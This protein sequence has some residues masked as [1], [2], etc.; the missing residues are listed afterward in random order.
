[1]KSE[2]VVQILKTAHLL[3]MNTI[4]EHCA[5]FMMCSCKPETCLQ[6]I[7][8]ANIY[9]LEDVAE[10]VQHVLEYNFAAV[11]KT[12]DFL[13]VSKDTLCKFLGNDEITEQEIDI[14]EACL[15]WIEHY[16]E[17][18]VEF[19][20]E[21]FSNIRLA[22]IK[23]PDL[24][25]RVLRCKF[26]N[27]NEGCTKLV[28]DAVQ[29]HS[30]VYSQPLCDGKI[31]QKRGMSC[32]LMI[33][34]EL[35]QKKEKITIMRH[36]GDA[37]VKEL[38]MIFKNWSRRTVICGGFLFMFGVDWKSNS[39][40]LVRV[41]LMTKEVLNL[42]PLPQKAT[43]GVAMSV[44]DNYIICAGGHFEHKQD[45]CRLGDF[46][47][48]VWMYNIAQNRWESNGKL[49]T[50]TAFSVSHRIATSG[51]LWI[52]GGFHS[53]TSATTTQF[54]FT[55][56]V[57]EYE[58]S[59]KIWLPKP[60][61][62]HARSTTHQ[63]CEIENELLMVV[64]GVEVDDLDNYC[65]AFTFESRQWTYIRFPSDEDY[66]FSTKRMATPFPEFSPPFLPSALFHQP[67]SSGSD[68][69]YMSLILGDEWFSYQ[70]DSK[71][72]TQASARSQ[73]LW[74]VFTID[75]LGMIICR[76]AEFIGPVK[77]QLK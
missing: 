11:S 13:D 50:P 8:L 34:Q 57:Y 4:V 7:R 77:L 48:R 5:D 30:N 53:Q 54:D 46:T 28:D 27:Q 49:P 70:S 14:F 62:L 35:P 67:G 60:N 2:N 23:M 19:F 9:H 75:R 24:V 16:E 40:C 61:M 69:S 42:C 20:A 37:T 56:N 21:I 33:Y 44:L 76:G 29:Y 72:W 64:G 41:D 26:V 63:V 17:E 12:A 59:G 15:R 58:P 68:V 51:K 25:S 6:Y 71:T 45:P 1:M 32:L 52:L 22:S 31:N 65:E 66:V 38:N 39:N 18:R 3:Q 47:D 74:K 36:P 10:E 43:H 73:F 55:S